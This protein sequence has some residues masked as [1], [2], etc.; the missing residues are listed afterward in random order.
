MSTHVSVALTALLMLPVLSAGCSPSASPTAPAVSVVEI[1]IDV[2]PNVLNIASQGEVVTVHT[3]L[4]FGQVTGSSV[5]LNGVTISSWK[6]DD[7]GQFV[8]KFLM[9]AVKDIPLTIGAFNRITL[10][11]K[12]IDERPFRGT[13]DILVVNNAAGA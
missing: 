7:R 10:E 4:P 2:S 6:A 11:G 12:T 13:Q 1:D 5:S 8:A 9:T 3:D